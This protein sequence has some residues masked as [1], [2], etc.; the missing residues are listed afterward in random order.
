M[1]PK[2]GPKMGPGGPGPA[3][4][5][6]YMNGCGHCDRLRPVWDETAS[7]MRGTGLGVYEIDA[8]TMTPTSS[9]SNSRWSDVLGL[10][11][12]APTYD[13]VPFIFFVTADGTLVPFEGN[14]D[15]DSIA[16]FVLAALTARPFA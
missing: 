7:K 10:V 6:V 5:L 4:G 8:S 12:D 2:M 15:R 11:R 9:P 1:G 13:G 16:R 14:R 3:L